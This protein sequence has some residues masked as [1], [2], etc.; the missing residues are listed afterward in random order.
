MRENR[1]KLGWL[2]KQPDC[3]K[4]GRQE[5]STLVYKASTISSREA[6]KNVKA[7]LAYWR[8]NSTVDLNWQTSS[9][10]LQSLITFTCG[11]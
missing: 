4:I 3:I 9:Q 5:A 8:K 7:V 11:S 10:L 2:A 6:V 1:R